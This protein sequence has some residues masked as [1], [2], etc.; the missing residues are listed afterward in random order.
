MTRSSSR[1]ASSNGSTGF[2]NQAS[3]PDHCASHASCLTLQQDH[4]HA[5][6]RDRRRR[7]GPS[8]GRTRPRAMRS[9]RPRR[10]R[11][12]RGAPHGCRARR[13]RRRGTAARRR[14][15]ARCCARRAPS[16][17]AN[18]RVRRDQAEHFH[19]QAI[20]LLRDLAGLD[21][22]GLCG[23]GGARLRSGPA[24]AGRSSHEEEERGDQPRK[25]AV[26]E[27]VGDVHA[28]LHRGRRGGPER[29]TG[30]STS[31]ESRSLTG[32][33]SRSWSR[34][35]W[36]ISGGMVNPAV[37]ISLWVTGKMP[38]TRAVV[39]IVAE[40]VGAVAGAF[41]LKALVPPR[42]LRCRQRRRP[43]AR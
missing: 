38:S 11:A 2:T 24:A 6:G 41:L 22:D 5:R 35:P 21:L 33:R 25:A 40:L 14:A 23:P 27:F 10:R 13:S 37:A 18:R 4:D 3:A 28:D 39:C 20:G 34:S 7:G 31:R 29:R 15:G 26:A 12:G 36:H 9:R 43:G 30:T 19:R 1:S 42:T 8:R 16:A 32:S 17:H